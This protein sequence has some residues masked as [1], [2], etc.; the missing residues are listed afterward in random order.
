MDNLLNSAERLSVYRVRHVFDREIANQERFLDANTERRLV[1]SC[2][3]GDK[4]AYAGLVH[5]HAGRVFTICF[6]M[7][8]NRRDAEDMAQQTLLQGLARIRSLR[9]SGLFGCGWPEHLLVGH[10][11]HSRA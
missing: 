10:T 9:D 3:N 11:L 6:G 8:G 2:K 4:A 5:A 1:A 7:L